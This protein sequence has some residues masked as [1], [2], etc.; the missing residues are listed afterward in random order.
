LVIVIA[1]WRNLS[2]RA[3][4]GDEER[5]VKDRFDFMAGGKKAK[6]MKDLCSSYL[7]GGGGD[8]D[9]LCPEE[10]G[11]QEPTGVVGRGKYMREGSK[12]DLGV[13]PAADR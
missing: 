9:H 2:A 3:R 8:F 5:T 4:G 12:A 10:V 7:P 6:N 13:T 11:G 1:V